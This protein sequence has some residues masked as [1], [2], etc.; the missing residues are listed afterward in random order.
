MEAGKVVSQAKP[1]L[2][3]IPL[4]RIK[5]GTYTRTEMCYLNS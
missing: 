5:W 4:V 2:E 3:A 1:P